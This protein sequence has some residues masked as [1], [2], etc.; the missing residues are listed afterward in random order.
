MCEE[1]NEPEKE[2]IILVLLKEHVQM[3]YASIEAEIMYKR[4]GTQKKANE[5][6]VQLLL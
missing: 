6:D 1:I 3:D 2:K 5:T 4:K